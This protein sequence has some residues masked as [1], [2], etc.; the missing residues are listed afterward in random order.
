MDDLQHAAD[1]L[2]LQRMDGFGPQRI[3]QL[4]QYFPTPNAFFTADPDSLSDFSDKL[5][6]CHADLQR[7]NHPLREQVKRDVA[8]LQEQQIQ[9]IHCQD[10]RYPPLLRE[11]GVPPPVLYIK[12]DSRYLLQPQLAVVGAR[13]AGQAALTVTQQWSKTLAEQGLLIT[14]GL[15]L[16]IDAAAHQ[17]CLQANQPTIAV[18]A[19]G[20][21]QIYP[22]RHGALAQQIIE[23]GA[24]VSEFPLGIEPK[25]DHFP[26]R[27]RIISGLSL[28]VWVVEAAL[29]SGSLITAQYAIEQNRE[30]FAMPGMIHNPVAQGCNWLIKQGASLVDEADDILT[31]LAW[32]KRV[33]KA[34]N[35][36]PD[37]A[38]LGLSEEAKSLLQYIPFEPVH[39]D[40]LMALT[41]RDSAELSPH[42]LALEIGGFIENR[43][44]NYQRIR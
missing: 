11:I 42:I 24:L 4:L 39:L 14:S 27:N 44:G 34:E 30:V 31:G 37:D 18:L 23:C 8:Y 33:Q 19:H 40:Q 41:R 32:Q 2:L 36:V 29:K 9:V 7:P 20:M 25:R 12:G 35:E 38:L 1:W 5:R 16:G 15:A 22:K 3:H 17:G 13:K 6:E 10:D 26:R 28:G 43:A 21:D